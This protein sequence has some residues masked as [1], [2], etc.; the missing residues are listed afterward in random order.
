MTDKWFSDIGAPG[1]LT[2]ADVCDQIEQ[3]IHLRADNQKPPQEF[4]DWQ[5]CVED[6]DDTIYKLSAAVVNLCELVKYLA[7]A[8]Q[9]SG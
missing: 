9:R 4:P 2:I 5:S 7:S 6:R 8:Q 1:E 3:K